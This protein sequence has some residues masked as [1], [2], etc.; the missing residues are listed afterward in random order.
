MDAIPFLSRS[1]RKIIVKAARM[2]LKNMTIATTNILDHQLVVMNLHHMRLIMLTIPMMNP[3]ST[4]FLQSCVYI[5]KVQYFYLLFFVLEGK[6]LKQ[7]K[8]EK[9]EKPR[10]QKTNRCLTFTCKCRGKSVERYEHRKELYI[11]M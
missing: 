6:M 11:D 10:T 7:P 1:W 2:K 5:Y 3:F 4:L 8:E 9:I